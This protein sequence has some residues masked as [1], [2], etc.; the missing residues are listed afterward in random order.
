MFGRKDT[1]AAAPTR[2]R[3]WV[4]PVVAGVVITAL[5]L[6]AAAWSI[7]VG[8]HGKDSSAADGEA[9]STSKPRATT[10]TTRPVVAG[11][12]AVKVGAQRWTFDVACNVAEGR[13]TA[14]GGDGRGATVVATFDRT[15]KQGSVTVSGAKGAWSIGPAGDTPISDVKVSAS[16]LE[17]RGKFTRREFGEPAKKDGTRPASKP[18]R[19]TAGS[20]T[21]TCEVPSG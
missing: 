11:T 6:T 13:I 3:R 9:T 10:T 2:R 4:R 16:H 8:D 14:Q 7:Q 12:A 15:T 20:Y 17:G 18:G 5:A 1:E 19:P 21:F